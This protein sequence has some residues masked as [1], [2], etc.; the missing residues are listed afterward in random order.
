MST[1]LLELLCSRLFII[2]CTHQFFTTHRA[3]SFLVCA[4]LAIMGSH[5]MNFLPTYS[6]DFEFRGIWIK[7]CLSRRKSFVLADL[8]TSTLRRVPGACLP[9]I[10]SDN[11]AQ[12]LFTLLTNHV[13]IFFFRKNT[14]QTKYLPENN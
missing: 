12:F 7:S 6:A 11:F 1:S 14:T 5:L 13:E 9:G 2:L 10:W 4:R 8:T 3:Y